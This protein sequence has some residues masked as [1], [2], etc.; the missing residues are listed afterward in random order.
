MT[1]WPG[2]RSRELQ[3]ERDRYVPKGM[4]SSIPVFA[5]S[6]DG[7]TLTDVDGNTYLDFATGISVM[8]LGHRHPRVGKAIVEQAKRL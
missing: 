1:D 7:V 5:E 4:G 8:N 6:A 3:A 2:P